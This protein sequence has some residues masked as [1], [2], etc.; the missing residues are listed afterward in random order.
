MSGTRSP[1]QKAPATEPVQ[2]RNKVGL[3]DGLI[4]AHGQPSDPAIGEAA[5]AQVAQRVM[6]LLPGWQIQAAT[7]AAP[8]RIE[9]ALADAPHPPY[10]YP[11]FMADGWFVRSALPGRL[12]GHAGKVLS[13]L[14]LD[15]DLPAVAAQILRQAGTGSVLIAAHG[16]ARSDWAAEAAQLFCNALAQHLPE[17]KIALGFV[18]QAPSIAQVAET[19]PETMPKTICL[20]FFALGGAHVTEDIPAMLAEA[21]FRGCLLPPLGEHDATAAVI[22]SALQQA[23]DNQAADNQATDTGET[24]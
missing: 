7:L 5:L 19:M 10:V 9:Q 3:R 21:G 23:A 4:V 14:G 22:A 15:P 2:S 17:R 8:G 18:E 11:L 16:S 13:P 12:G 1:F 24:T 20:P 6:A